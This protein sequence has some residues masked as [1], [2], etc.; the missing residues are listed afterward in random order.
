MLTSETRRTEK[1]PTDSFFP[2]QG[3]DDASQLNLGLFPELAV[4]QTGVREAQE[5]FLLPISI[6]RG[7]N[8]GCTVAIPAPFPA[9]VPH[10]LPSNRADGPSRGTWGM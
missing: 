1:V 9:S 10:L 5:G 4:H 7:E 3:L 6:N 8:K 2:S